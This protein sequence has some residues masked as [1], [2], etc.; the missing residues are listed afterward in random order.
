MK[1]KVKSVVVGK[2]WTSKH[3]ATFYN[4]DYEFED[5]VKL[6]ASH[7]TENP[8]KQGDEVEYEIK[9]TD[10]TYGNKGSV[11]KPDDGGG[12]GGGR[13]GGYSDVGVT[14]GNALNN[15]SLL[16]AHG[17]IEMSDLPAVA[18]RI[19]KTAIDLKNKYKDQF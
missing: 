9:S 15:A 17:K 2:E 10:E 7:K 13:R 6:Q 18:E 11:K 3:G 16:A 19:I 12:F 5:G 8:F 14:V 4:H 1:S